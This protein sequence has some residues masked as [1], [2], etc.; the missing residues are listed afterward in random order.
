MWNVS[1]IDIEKAKGP[2]YRDLGQKMGP[3]LNTANS[4]N[5]YILSDRA[6]WLA[7]RNRGA[8]AIVVEGDR[9]LFNQYGVMLVNPNR[10]PTVK[11][12]LGQAFIDWILSPE[13]QQ[14]IADYRI[15]GEQ[16][17]FPNAAQSGA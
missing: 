11:K 10:H 2:W 1:G 15:G 7:F 9:R 3:A 6:T 5:A 8:L 16:L 14:A 4:L 17:F 12:A 13:G